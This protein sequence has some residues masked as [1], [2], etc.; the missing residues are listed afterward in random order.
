MMKSSFTDVKGIGPA[1]LPALAEQGITSVKQ[2]AEISVARLVQIR[3]FSDARAR[4]V[5]RAAKALLRSTG[6]SAGRASTTKTPAARTVAKK[7]VKESEKKTKKSKKDKKSRK[8]E[9][10]GKKSKQEKKKKKAK[11]AAKGKKK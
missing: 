7:A 8:A 5:I 6:Q 4:N 1:T 2:L 10:S 9:K 3:G 11:K